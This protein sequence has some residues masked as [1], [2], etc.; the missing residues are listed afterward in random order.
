MLKIPNKF[1]LVYSMVYMINKIVGEYSYSFFVYIYHPIS[2]ELEMRNS[3]MEWTLLGR[4]QEFWC[5][6]V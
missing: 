4:R 6:G 5:G 1:C 3:K 2:S